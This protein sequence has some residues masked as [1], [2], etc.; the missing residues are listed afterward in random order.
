M[1][2]RSFS[3][4]IALAALAIVGLA[5]PATAGE[6]VPFRGI[7]EGSFTS[8]LIPGTPNALVVAIGTGQAT[9]LGQFSFD[10]PLTVNLATQTGSGTYTLTAAN[11]DTVVA[12]VIA[13]SSVLPNGLRLVEEIG[14][15]T[16]G[17]GR[18]ANASG[19]FIGERTLDRATGDVIGFFDGTISSPGADNP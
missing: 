17:T 5:G 16:G 6:Q 4:R 11:G 14:T 10:F 9:L 12:E 7:V 18:F 1:L 8:T 2:R 19:G 3:V 13:K 15:I